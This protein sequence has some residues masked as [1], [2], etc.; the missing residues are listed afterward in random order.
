[1]RCWGCKAENAGGKFCGECGA[2]LLSG[3][4]PESSRAE[5]R[6]L[7]VLFC[8]L[9]GSTALSERLDPEDLRDVVQAYQSLCGAIIR[10]HDGHVAQYLGDGLLVYFGYP[11]AHEDDAR[12]AVRA[13]L[14]IVDAVRTVQP[15]GDPLQVR[16]GIHSGL[17]VV[18]EIGEGSRREQLALGETPNFAN[19]VQ[20][21]AQPGWVV[22]SEATERLVRG[23][24][25]IDE[26]AEEAP[27]RRQGRPLRLFR[28]LAATEATSRIDATS[29]AGW[30]PF[31]GRKAEVDFLSS[32][33]TGA[34]AGTGS[35]ILIRGEP[36][37]GKS[38]L[39][40]VIKGWIDRDRNDLL[41]C[42]CSP[43]YQNSAL[44][45]IIEMLERRLGYAHAARSDAEKKSLEER[46]V[47][48]GLNPAEAVP[49]LAP[50][51][52][53]PVGV[54]YPP[55]AMA[56]PKQR[57]RTLE[58]LAECL[59]RLAMR[60]P[61][62][63]ILEDLHW[64][65]PT[66]LELMKVVLGRQ[67]TE[68][69]ARLLVLLTART[70]FP[71]GGLA[72]TAEMNLQPL[73]REDSKTLVAHLTG[74]K[75]LP[76]EVLGQLLAR[77]GGVPLFVE[78]LTKAVLE[79]GAFREL[80]DR[81]ELEGPMPAS[82]VPP[83][84]H[85]SLMA[86][87]DRLGESKPLAQLAATL[88]R[89]FRHEV[90]KSVSSLDDATLER[91]L[92][93][94]VDAELVYRKGD[95][96]QTVY[97]FKHALI[98][99]AAYDSLLRKTRQEYH[100]RIARTLAEVFPHL[101][102]SEPELLARHYEGAGM[103]REAIFH[104][105]RAGMG[106]MTRAANLEAIAHLKH[107]VELVT[108][109]P[110]TTEGLQQELAIQ[111]A[112]GPAQMAIKGW[113]ST[114]V[115]AASAR[116]LA[117]A[118]RLQTDDGVFRS[119]WGLWT[120]YFLRGQLTEALQTG[121]QA[122][123]LAYKADGPEDAKHARFR[124]MAH[125]AVGYSHFYRGNFLRAREHAEQ[126]LKLHSLETE[127]LIVRD[128]Q[129]SSSAALQ[130][131][132]GSSLW[133][134][135]YPDQA[136]VE[137]NLG[138]ALTRKLNHRPSEAYALAASLLLHS[139]QLDVD[140]A[141]RTAA[142]LLTLAAREGFEIWI[143][144]ATMFNGWTL[145]ERGHFDQGIREIREGITRWQATGSYLNQTIAMA[146]LGLSL[147]KAGQ[148]DEALVILEAEMIE[149][150]ARAELHFAPELHRLKGE[151]LVE[152]GM[153]AEAEACFERA[154]LL[155]RQQSARMLELR[156][157]TSLGRIWEQTGR[158]D[159]ALALVTEIYGGFTEGF[160]TPDLRAAQELLDR[161]RHTVSAR[162]EPPP[163]HT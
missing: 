161:L 154:R 114:E 102:D 54:D 112:L 156:A 62:L 32:A 6:H 65:D 45:P 144:F 60:R 38:R 132:K 37:I 50:L 17:V 123:T 121:E 1:M 72:C 78:E 30:S 81:Y 66:T 95:P 21:C 159:A 22:M 48:L 105:Q 15:G 4:L 55:L 70:E 82:V 35:S 64:A 76:D 120:M 119:L 5:R 2:S 137:V 89:E 149:A 135:G 124:L 18:G 58:L 57:Q 69:T 84:V 111:L 39:I 12:R 27:L 49:L 142:E 23:F 87:L 103:A 157:T 93:R 71:A 126:G 20:T 131:I 122:L 160:T 139:Y 163:I 140:G 134:L 31:V 115:E 16:V 11:S 68:S 125:H 24:F 106:A 104:W 100:Q 133:M 10:R 91:D 46:L 147:W 92:G 101:M 85:D 42:R 141:A 56:P 9:V 109:Q 8:D 162:L 90:I 53:I 96:L 34:G 67:A 74:R 79:G 127:V 29:T 3:A 77:A 25:R 59:I 75:A 63:F 40:A 98:Q 36:G 155:A 145:V 113:A 153:I 130:I 136:P 151:V 51:F 43:Y 143:P 61:T 83:S 14:E 13:G 118:T 128:T 148:A 86:R 88:G 19:H 52:S 152:R 26:M 146:M 97:I 108:A 117:L 73:A 28:I 47:G 41:E 80:E 138:I 99:D 33:W 107:A 150:E 44:H 94:L 158:A 110:S 116:A 129:L 7:T